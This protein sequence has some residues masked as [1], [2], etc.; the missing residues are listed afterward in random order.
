MEKISCVSIT[1]SPRELNSAQIQNFQNWIISMEGTPSKNSKIMSIETQG[2]K[3]IQSGLIT[4]IRT[5]NIR[6]KLKSILDWDN[7]D[8]D[9]KKVSLAIKSHKDWNYLIG[10]CCKQNDPLYTNIDED[11]LIQ[12]KDYYDT[13]KVGLK[14]N[15]NKDWICSGLNTL[16]PT[17]YNWCLDNGL[18]PSTTSF[19]VICTRLVSLGK[20]PFSLG[21]KIKREDENY[22]ID[23]CLVKEGDDDL[24]RMY[25][26]Y[27]EEDEMV[28]CRR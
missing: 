3:H 8:D 27:W 1:F 23:Y 10:Y 15:T 28:F 24:I 19:R 12:C 26:Y 4:K 17:C 20:I 2:K 11:I 13:I 6:R 25:T 22:W 14:S 5:D 16:L 9:E 21:R 18:N 7:L